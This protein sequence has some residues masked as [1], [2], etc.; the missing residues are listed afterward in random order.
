MVIIVFSPLFGCGTLGRSFHLS[1]LQ[2][3]MLQNEIIT[4]LNEDKIS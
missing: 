2:L 4:V 1:V 3:L